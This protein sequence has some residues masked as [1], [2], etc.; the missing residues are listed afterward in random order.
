MKLNIFIGRYALWFTMKKMSGATTKI[1]Y[2]N[3]RLKVILQR[4][5]CFFGNL[6]AEN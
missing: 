3:W 5:V 2:A 6:A 4:L 1:L